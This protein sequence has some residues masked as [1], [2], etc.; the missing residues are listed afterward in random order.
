MVMS[1][2]ERDQVKALLRLGFKESTQPDAGNMAVFYDESDRMIYAGIIKEWPI[3]IATDV[4]WGKVELKDTLKE[5]F[6]GKKIKFFSPFGRV[7]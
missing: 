5:P 2:Q 6:T 7:N 4:E 1:S 3:I